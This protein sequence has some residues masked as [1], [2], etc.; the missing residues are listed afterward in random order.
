MAWFNDLKVGTKILV[1]VT[2]LLALMAF[3]GVFSIIQTSKVNKVASEIRNNWLPSIKLLAEIDGNI[4]E[5]RRIELANI[6]AKTKEEHDSFDKRNK[7]AKEKY[8]KQ[9]Y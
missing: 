5:I 7:A 2:I 3:Q 6:N 4:N 9:D 8:A 1:T